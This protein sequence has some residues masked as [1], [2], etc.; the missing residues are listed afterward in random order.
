MRSPGFFVCVL[1]VLL[2]SGSTPARAD[3][4]ELSALLWFAR[5]L[6]GS[7]TILPASKAG[8][9]RPLVED[10]Q[11]D[12]YYHVESIATGME[13]WVYR[14]FG[15]RYAGTAPAS[16]PTAAQAPAPSESLSP[17]TGAAATGSSR[18]H[19]AIDRLPGLSVGQASKE[20]G[21][22]L[23]NGLPDSACTPG[24]IDK[25]IQLPRKKGCRLFVR[26][27]SHQIRSRQDNERQAKN[28]V[29]RCIRRRTR[30]TPG[31]P[32]GCAK[33]IL[34][35]LQL[36]GADTM[37]NLWPECSMATRIGRGLAFAIGRLR[38]LPLFHV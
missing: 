9:S 34:V 1:V 2:L 10:V 30:P 19:S 36:G 29:Y 6:I 32:A 24:D 3:Y 11:Q 12:G 35:A 17:P 26:P 13:G 16:A 28:E 21:W 4:L 23:N 22:P 33:W 18:D 7:R 27:T 31:Q 15:R 37:P 14:T 5:A 20:E 38:E 8:R 25:S